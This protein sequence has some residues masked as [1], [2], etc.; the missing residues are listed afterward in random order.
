MKN[1]KRLFSVILAC[2]L[3]VTLVCAALA[4]GKLLTIGNA[5]WKKPCIKQRQTMI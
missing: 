4:E 1:K 5:N 3:C 2:A